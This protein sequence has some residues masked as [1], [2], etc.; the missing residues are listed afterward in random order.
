MM[1]FCNDCI[2]TRSKKQIGEVERNGEVVPVFEY[3]ERT[4]S[5]DNIFTGPKCHALMKGNEVMGC[6]GGCT[7]NTIGG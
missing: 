1:P 3:G 7:R 6:T 5:C 4:D 2:F